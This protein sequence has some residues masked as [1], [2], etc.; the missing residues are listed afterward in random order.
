MRRLPR[1]FCLVSG[2]DDLTLLPGLA[3]AGIRGFRIRDKDLTTRALIALTRTVRAA[4]G[5]ALVSVDDRVDV[6]LATGADGVHLGTDDL[7]PL[8]ARLMAPRLLI[9]ATCRTPG[10]VATARAAGADYATFGPVF[11]AASN[12]G[13][14]A[15]LGLAAVTEA[16]RLLPLVAVGGLNPSRAA[17]VRTAGAHGVTVGGSIWRQPDPVQAAKEL[18]A[19]VFR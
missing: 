19:A 6:A 10:A 17:E 8:D 2:D 12:T 16:A 1:I 18:A 3:A 7:P 11:T 15:P 13:L 5:S 9:G 4:V 14:R